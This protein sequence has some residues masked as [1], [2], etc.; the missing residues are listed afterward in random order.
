MARSASFLIRLAS[1]S[2]VALA[3]STMAA[4]SDNGGG[5][6]SAV[7]IPDWPSVTE[8]AIALLCVG[9]AWWSLLRARRDRTERQLIETMLDHNTHFLAL[10]TPQGLCTRTNRIA[11]SWLSLDGTTV[12]T[13]QR[14]QADQTGLSDE[15][16]SRSAMANTSPSIASQAIWDLPVWDDNT[17]QRDALRHAVQSA[18][19]GAIGRLEVRMKDGASGDRFVDLWIRSIGLHPQ[20]PLLIEG[21]D[22]TTRRHAEEKL[23]LA[24][25][26]FEQ[27]R[28]G[29]VIADHRGVILSANAAFGD[30]TGY[31]IDDIQGES[32]RTLSTM[33]C[34]P[35]RTVQIIETVESQGRWHGEVHCLHRDGTPF[36]AWL[37]LSRRS[38]SEGR[39]RHVIGILNDITDIRQAEQ[40]LLRHTQFDGLTDL[41]NRQLL[42]ERLNQALLTSERT[43]Q[44][45]ALL[46]L[47]VN[48]LRHINDNFGHNAGDGVLQEVGSRLK[49][50][51]READTVAR[52]GGDE[53]AVLLPG[54]SHEGAAQV[55]DKLLERLAAPCVFGAHEFSLTFSIGIATFP[56]D[57]ADAESLVRCADTAMYR[58]KQ[59]GRGQWCFYTPEMLHRSVRQ[60]QLE[61]AL[62]RAEERKELQLHYQ[63]QVDL[64]TG[65]LIGMEALIRWQHPELG[66]ISPAEFIPLAESS[67]Q[68]LAIGAWVLQ[69]A[70]RQLKQ[71]IDGGLPPTVVAVNL[72]AVQFRDPGL[73]ELVASTLRESGLPP[74][75]LELELTESVAAH[76]PQAARAMMDQLHALGV[77]LS[78]D[79]FGT[80]FSSLNH[81][82][83]FPIHTLK[84]DQS[85]VRDITTDPDD[86]AIVQAIIQMARA[87]RLTTVAEGVETDEQAEFLHAHGCEAA[88]GYRFCR[89]LPAADVL[90]W[91]LAQQV[92]DSQSA[93]P[94]QH[95]EKTEEATRSPERVA[96]AVH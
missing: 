35:A 37:S 21:R 66:M 44:P 70:V 78:I 9:W 36:T 65:Q 12:C 14:A 57:A 88:Q 95:Q 72:S 43:E 13:D 83:R 50:S 30:I 38:D 27:T 85:F 3:N 80:G 11:Q 8:A 16:A 59:Q 62:R 73:P 52:L 61:A 2:I 18:T 53:F 39:S 58:A 87:L 55:A 1:L 74:A 75:C 46:F 47:D 91:M 4:S 20:D 84:V 76:N 71:W 45:M 42:M 23:M 32:L 26:V 6:P 92:A 25:A 33:V 15:R 86:R 31:R 48:Q 22:I 24:A 56:G 64:Q 34:D 41:P 67:G 93:Q 60:L 7:W 51:L 29:V 28:E 54:T 19:R 79:D 77:R 81:L 82:K 89:P 10:I 5:T 17:E 40:K 94:P 68:I 90:Q 63:P 69:T 49:H 96:P